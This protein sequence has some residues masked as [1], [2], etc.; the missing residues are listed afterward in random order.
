L[1]QRGTGIQQQTA[2]LLFCAVAFAAAFD[3]QR[4]DA[5]FEMQVVSRGGCGQG[6][7]GE[8]QHPADHGGFYCGVCCQR[9]AGCRNRVFARYWRGAG[10]AR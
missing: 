9:A 6:D 2:F 4:S 8:E 1:Q 5:S 3:Q 7:E 10:I